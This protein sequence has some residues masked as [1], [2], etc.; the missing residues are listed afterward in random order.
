MRKITTHSIQLR[1]E[2]IHVDMG[3]LRNKAI[4]SVALKIRSNYNSKTL[5]N[6]RTSC[7]KYWD[8]FN[9]CINQVTNIS[10]SNIFGKKI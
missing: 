4:H 8:S 9:S 6:C 2:T 1:I 5:T 10:N 7:I 3:T